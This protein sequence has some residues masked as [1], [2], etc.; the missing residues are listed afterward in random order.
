MGEEGGSQET[1]RPWSTREIRYLREHAGDGAREIA[2][3]LGRTTEAVKLQARK[4]G[5][6]LRQR[7][8][9]PKCGR[10]TFKPLNKA[11]GWCAECTKEGHVADLREQAS[12]MREE[13]ARSKRTTASG[14][15]ATAPRAARKSPKNKDPKKHPSPDLR[16]HKKGTQDVHIQRSERPQLPTCEHSPKQPQT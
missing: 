7:W 12:A 15:G 3:A 2:K 11:N 9:C 5:I 4:C 10:M 16:K 14:R 6:S 1:V 8:M 13:A